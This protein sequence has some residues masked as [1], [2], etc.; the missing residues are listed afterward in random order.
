MESVSQIVKLKFELVISICK[1]AQFN[2]MFSYNQIAAANVLH[3]TNPL[4]PR[5]L[6]IH[7][8][9]VDFEN[10]YMVVK[11]LWS[12]KVHVEN[13]FLYPFILALQWHPPECYFNSMYKLIHLNL[14][15]LSLFN[16]NCNVQAL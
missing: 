8:F 4:K 14:V 1:T 13:P 11:W 6:P 7:F 10:P 15:S 5:P 2:Q 3:S 12:N 9:N 16:A